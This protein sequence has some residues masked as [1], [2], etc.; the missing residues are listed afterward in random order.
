MPLLTK[1][2]ERL[3]V[4]CML[5]PVVSRCVHQDSQRISVPS[6]MA[7][8]GRTE[9]RSFGGSKKNGVCCLVEPVHV[10]TF[11]G[12]PRVLVGSPYRRSYSLKIH[13]QK[14]R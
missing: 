14:H 13:K 11:L 3:A 4:G 5:G 9:K 12:C 2:V 8:L 7:R 10:C 1:N 6:W